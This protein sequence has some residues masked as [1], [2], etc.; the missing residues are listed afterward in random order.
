M[1]ETS[2]AVFQQP[3]PPAAAAY[4]LAPLFQHKDPPVEKYAPYKP[5]LDWV[6][7]P[8]LWLDDWELYRADDVQEGKDRLSSLPAEILLMITSHLTPGSL[9]AVSRTSRFLRSL[10]CTKRAEPVWTAARQRRG[11]PDLEAGGLNEVEYA[12]LVEGEFCCL[13]GEAERCE[14]GDDCDRSDSVRRDFRVRT[15]LCSDCAANLK[16]SESISAEYWYLHPLTFQCCLSTQNL[17]FVPQVLKQ[18]AAL[19]DAEA[20][21]AGQDKLLSFG[22]EVY[23]IKRRAFLDA[24]KLDAYFLKANAVTLRCDDEEEE[25]RMKKLRVE[26]FADIG[27]TKSWCMACIEEDYDADMKRWEDEQRAKGISE[28]EEEAEAWEEE[29]ENTRWERTF[30]EML[31]AWHGD[32]IPAPCHLT[33]TSPFE[34]D[35]RELWFHED[36]P[37]YRGAII[38]YARRNQH[39]ARWQAAQDARRRRKEEMETLFVGLRTSC[40]EEHLGFFVALSTFLDF[41]EVKALWF[42]DNGV[43]VSAVELESWPRVRQQILSRIAKSDRLATIQ[44]FDRIARSLLNDGQRLGDF[45]S[46]VLDREPSPFV[47][48]D[49][50]KGLAPYHSALSDDDMNPVFDRLASLFRCGVCSAKLTF[51]AIAIHLVDEHGLTNVAAYAHVPTPSFRKAI[52]KL[53]ERRLLPADI[54]PA[55]FKAYHGGAH[56]HVTMRTK[57]GNLEMSLNETW[58]QVLS[59]KSLAERHAA[60]HKLDYTSTDRDIA[61]IELSYACV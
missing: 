42:P 11:W 3:V 16:P 24:V 36:W 50:S 31:A 21:A 27:K 56:F 23:T 4:K 43:G 26:N 46:F 5:N 34:G 1:A 22:S 54:S 29:D 15:V 52:K 45:A 18:S 37:H 30:A 53:L 10:T 28:E 19:Y 61:K 14:K 55:R 25:E 58:A 17:Y 7:Q 35:H 38:E 6:K 49:R 33:E 39:K 40:R 59:G 47:D 13:C 2:E 41:P 20:D 8:E 60:W 9:V 48:S 51:P 44:L 12:K 32:C 57:T